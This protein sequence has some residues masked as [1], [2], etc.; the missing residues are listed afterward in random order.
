MSSSTRFEPTPATT[1]RREPERGSYD[2]DVVYTIL[3]EAPFCHL[4]FI[5]ESRPVVVPTIHVRVGDRL[6]LHGS[7]ASRMMRALG[8]GE[9]IAVA[10]TLLDG[11]VLARSVFHHSMNYRSVVLFG[12]GEE[13]TD[14]DAKLEA[15]RVF[16]EKIL[17]GRW[18]V[19]R[20]PTEKE[21]RATMMVAVPIAEASAKVRTGPP[22]DEEHDYHLDVWAGVI[23]LRVV[24]GEPVPDPHLA[25]GIPVP[26][27]VWNVVDQ[28]GG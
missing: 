5:H 23:P 10:V 28:T 22:E 7:P 1:V 6:V 3:D 19:V 11:L 16:T 2:R 14:L 13:I 9:R 26:E 12:T 20:P 8:S 27:H 18:G 15:M 17:P 4:G 21:F 25:S 24:A